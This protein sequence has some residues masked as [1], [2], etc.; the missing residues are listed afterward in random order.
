[1]VLTRFSL[2]E[3]DTFGQ[4]FQ[5][6]STNKFVYTSIVP[7]LYFFVPLYRGG[8]L[9]FLGGHYPVIIRRFFSFNT[10]LSFP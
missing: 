9:V 3:I 4:T 1:M 6:F 8:S 7:P 10:E 5:T 2:S